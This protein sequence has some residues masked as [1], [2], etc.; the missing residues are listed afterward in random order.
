MSR[1]VN[2]VAVLFL[3]LAMLSLVG[4]RPAASSTDGG[5]AGPSS[6]AM[7]AEETA[8]SLAV[9]KS[10]Q[11]LID[12]Q[13]TCPVSGAALGS[14]GTPVKVTV[15]GGTVFLCCSGC[16]AALLKDPDKYLEKLDKQA[17]K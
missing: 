11:E 13:K 2:F 4:L 5:S 6:P 17:Q 1:K 7:T 14:M 8:S 3:G 10:D 15:K 9:S 12:K 16:K